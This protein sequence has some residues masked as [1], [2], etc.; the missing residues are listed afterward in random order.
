MWYIDIEFLGS[1]FIAKSLRSFS[2]VFP[3][4]TLLAFT[5]TVS[6]NQRKFR[7]R[8]SETSDLVNCTVDGTFA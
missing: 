2:S 4:N 5:Q 1:G 7:N 3:L 6:S 8:L